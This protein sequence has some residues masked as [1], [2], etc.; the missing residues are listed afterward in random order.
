MC[1][2][3]PARGKGY[4]YGASCITSIL[5]N[6]IEAKVKLASGEFCTCVG[7]YYLQAILSGWK[8]HLPPMEGVQFSSASTNMYPLGI[9]DTNLV[10]PHPEGSVGTKTEIVIMENCASQHIILQSYYLNIYVIYIN[11]HED[12]D[13]TIGE[14]KRQRFSLSNMPKQISVISA[15]KVTYKEGFVAHQLIEA[16]INPS[17]NI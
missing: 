13:F 6:D 5:M 10:F 7:K 14:K 8:N 17:V 3:K 11:N 2:V 16:I 1:K 15:V 12:R 4:T 9:S